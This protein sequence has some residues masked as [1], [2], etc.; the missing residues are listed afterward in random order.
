MHASSEEGR[1]RKGLLFVT[2][3]QDSSAGTVE[4][5]L[6]PTTRFRR[7]VQDSSGGLFKILLPLSHVH[8]IITLPNFHFRQQIGDPCL[9][10]LFLNRN[11]THVRA[12]CQ[13]LPSPSPHLTSPPLRGLPSA[14]HYL[15]PSVTAL[16]CSMQTVRNICI[17]TL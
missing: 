4:F 14:L 16:M 12:R 5:P 10:R 11:G 15:Q 17:T 3:T 1:C 7:G 8:A 13:G 2:C 9:M 6:A